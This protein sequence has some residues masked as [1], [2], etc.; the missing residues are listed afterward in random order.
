M[1]AVLSLARGP[2]VA[3]FHTLDDRGLARCRAVRRGAA[4]GPGE[5]HRPDRGLRGRPPGAGRA[6]R[7]RRGGDPQRR[8]GRP[9]RHAPS[10][11]R[12]TRGRG[13]VG[14]LGR[15]DEPRKG[16]PV[17]L[18]ALPGSRR[19]GPTCGC[20]S[21]V[22][23]DADELLPR[24]RS[25]SCAA[26]SSCSAW[27]ARRTRR[28]CSL[29]VDVYCAPNTRRRELRDHPARG[30]G[31]RHP[32]RGQR[33]RRRSAGCSTTAGPAA[34]PRPAT[35]ARWREA[36]AG[37]LDDPA[38][39]QRLAGVGTDVVA[40][41]RLAGRGRQIVAVYE[42]VVARDPVRVSPDTSATARPARRV[43]RAPTLITRGGD[44]RGRRRDRRPLRVGELDRQPA[45][46]AARPHRLARAALDAALVRR[47]AA[48]QAAA[49][50]TRTRARP[51]AGG[52]AAR[53][54][55]RARWTPAT[56]AARPRRTTCP[57][58]CG[59]SRPAPTRR[60]WPTSRLPPAGWRWPAVPQRRGPRHRVAAP[61]PDAAAAA[62]GR[63]RAAAGVL[64]DRRHGARRSPDRV[65]DVSG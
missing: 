31:G 38:R 16:L 63:R 1:L 55:R 27:S 32:G 41:I 24:G 34:V 43:S 39:R 13:T 62:P 23:G 25:G 46:P 51:A 56:A 44:D 40:G 57:G 65:A 22:R 61:P 54:G 59:A 28:G 19:T 48:L 35:P 33:P 60:G 4:A 10:R 49:P 42:T 12:A 18:E 3:T 9:L 6:P 52:S 58:R 14:F 2:I 45:G 5:D 29:A 37:L 64:R 20:W 36:L 17:L 11:C 50:R 21:P 8:R 30:D 26:G 7:R 15:F 53:A 47:A